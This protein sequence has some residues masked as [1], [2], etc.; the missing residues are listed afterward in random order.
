MTIKARIVFLALSLVCLGASVALGA[1]GKPLAKCKD[2]ATMYSTTGKH[3]FACSGHGGVAAWLDG[4]P[5][6]AKK[7]PTTSYR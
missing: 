4:S 6:K 3:Q 7:A 1:E 2:G 5:V